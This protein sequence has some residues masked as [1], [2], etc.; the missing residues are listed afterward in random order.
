LVG[1]ST[2]PFHCAE[3]E[4]D[5]GGN[6]VRVTFTGFGPDHRPRSA[7][8]TLHA[9]WDDNLVM[10]RAWSWGSYVDRLETQVLPHVPAPVVTGDWG[11]E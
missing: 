2:Q 7:R 6:S 10:V 9:A 8:T 1:D 4:G 5:R 3:R 11:A